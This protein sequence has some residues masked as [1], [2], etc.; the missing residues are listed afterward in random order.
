MTVRVHT[1]IRIPADDLAE[2]DR[3]A[4]QH[5][6]SRSEYLIRAGTGRL[7]TTESQL[8]RRLEAVERRLERLEADHF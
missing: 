1:A 5:D 7:E 2:I 8:A 3:Q 6:L 4:R